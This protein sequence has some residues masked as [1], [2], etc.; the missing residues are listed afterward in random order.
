ML[1]V[2]P[3]LRLARFDYAEGCA[4]AE[5]L[6]GEVVSRRLDLSGIEMTT[7]RV[8]SDTD[9]GEYLY[10]WRLGPHGYEWSII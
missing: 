9:R 5:R 3:I 6:G 8:P 7:Y 1:I 4:A 2:K 10:V